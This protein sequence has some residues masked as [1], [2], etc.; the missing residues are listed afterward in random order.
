MGRIAFVFSGQGAQHPGM[1]RDLYEKYDSVKKIFEDAEKIRPGITEMCHFGDSESLKQTENTQP[2]LYLADLA[3]ALALKQEGILPDGAAGFSLGEIA[4]LAFAGVFD[5]SEGFEIV[6]R[7]G[8]LM[9]EE[10]RKFDTGMA[11][12]LKLDNAAIESVAEKYENVYPVNYNCPGQLVVSGLREEIAAFS[13][14]IKS[15][16]GRVL[17]LAVSGAFHSPYMNG[18]AE[19]FGQYLD[20]RDFGTPNIPVYSNFTAL[21]YSKDEK[22]PNMLRSQMNHPVR[23]EE[24]IRNMAEDGFDTFIEAGV[25]NTLKKL[26]SKTLPDAKTFAVEDISSLEKAVSELKNQ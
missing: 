6:C 19:K 26:I 12:I 3:A 14:E 9:G 15:I 23:W 13:D 1:S 22:I 20:D 25:G 2:C 8:E 18:A 10:N 16:G 11:A 5:I 24:T 17:P 7:R 21:P 4:A